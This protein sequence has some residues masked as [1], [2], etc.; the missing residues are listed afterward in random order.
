V[1][2]QQA[3]DDGSAAAPHGADDGPIGLLGGSFDPVHAGHLQLA[4][5][6]QQGLALA[7][8]WFVPAGQ[9][10]QKHGV[11]PAAD[12]LRMLELALA[13]MAQWRIDRR[14]IDRDGPTYTIDTAGEL[15][16]QWGPRRPLVWLMGFDQLARLPT[17]HRWRELLGQLH[18][19][20]ALR[21]GT[22]ARLEAVMQRYEQAHRG[23][24]Q[25][26][27][28]EAAGRLVR[29]AMQPVDCS[30][31]QIRRALA[32]GSPQD[33]AYAARHVPAPVLDYIRERNLYAAEH[34][35]EKTAAPGR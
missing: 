27:Q 9:P 35:H 22:G 3:P 11:T 16:R 24:A 26:L 7:Q 8:V 21:P 33:A 14:E 23:A 29:F 4:R 19:A 28:R 1:N 2:R 25:D 5:D 12:R 6:A 32:R 15:R 31:T 20:Y 13:P 18:I 30:A 10:W 17:W 34:G